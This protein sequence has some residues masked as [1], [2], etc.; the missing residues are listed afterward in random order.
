MNP[1][2]QEQAISVPCGGGIAVDG[3]W[4]DRGSAPVGV[5]L[6]GFRSN[7]DGDKSLGLARHAVVRGYSWLRFNMH[8]GSES[9]MD[10][11]EFRLGRA[12]AEA[13]CV[14]DWLAPRQVVLA[15]SSMGGWLA[16]WLARERPRQVCGLLLI[17]PAFNFIQEYFGA[18]PEAEKRQWQQCGT[19]DFVDLYS[20]ESYRLAFDMLAEARHYDIFQQETFPDRPI[21][22]IHG[23]Y[24]EVVPLAVS[25]GFQ[26]WLGGE[27]VALTVVP[28]G[29]H[30][31]NNAIP[32]L[33]G[34]LD[35]VWRKAQECL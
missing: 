27:R 5:F 30:R 35:R 13:R 14:L 10:F 20:G 26:R 12:L 16:A 24:D 15:G 8:G 29:D 2:E 9:R 31:L 28:H 4:S 21:A 3:Y 1:L 32:L 17:A 25:E 34:Q 18:L 11:S 22:V 19:R 7:C 33:C 6:H 23:E